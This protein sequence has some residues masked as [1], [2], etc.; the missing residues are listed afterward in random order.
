MKTTEYNTPFVLTQVK[1][2]Q[3]ILNAHLKQQKLIQRHFQA[4]QKQKNWN[5]N[6][7]FSKAEKL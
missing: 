5:V 4:N 3:F 7:K 6:V 2:R 1:T